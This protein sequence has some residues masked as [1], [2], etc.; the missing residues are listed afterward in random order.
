MKTYNVDAVEY[1]FWLF[2]PDGK[3][4]NITDLIETAT[5]T[6]TQE[7]I[8]DTVDL[9]VKNEKIDN[10]WLHVDLYLARRFMIEAKDE[11]TNWTEVFRGTFTSWQTNAADFTVNSTVTDGNQMLIGNDIIRYFPDGTAESRVKRMLSDI[12]LPIEKIEGLSTSLTKELA[13]SQIATKIIEYKDKAEEKTGIKT[14]IRSTKGKFEIVKRGTNS[15]VYV[16]DSLATRSG[17][18][19]HS[20]PN[21]FATIVKVYGSA[22]GDKMPPLQATVSGDTSFGKH[23]KVIYSSDYKSSAEANTAAKNILKEQG[24][25]ERF[26]S[27]KGHVDIPFLRVGDAVD[28]MVGT[29]GGFENGRQ[30]PARRYVSALSRDFVNQTMDLELEV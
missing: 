30:V 24:K 21:D 15:K 4:K 12:G 16:L 14:V 8:V 5:L 29:I 22:D 28:V 25:P 23:T 2:P 6:S 26:Q 3:R 18:D 13:K 17:A 1:R 27:I 19:I 20:I 10:Q 7:G 11:D 9:H